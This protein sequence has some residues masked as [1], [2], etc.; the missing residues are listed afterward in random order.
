MEARTKSASQA[1]LISQP[2]RLTEDKRGL[3]G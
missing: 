3:S 2:Q 1:A